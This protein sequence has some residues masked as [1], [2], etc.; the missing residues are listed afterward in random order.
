MP[1][2]KAATKIERGLS[3]MTAFDKAW[4]IVKEDKTGYMCPCGHYNTDGDLCDHSPCNSCDDDKIA[5]ADCEG[6]DGGDGA[7]D[8]CCTCN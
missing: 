5:S 6:C 1:S 7:C 3:K 4:G 8:A 2:V